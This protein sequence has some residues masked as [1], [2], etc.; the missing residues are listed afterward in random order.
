MQRIIS[1]V[2]F[3]LFFLKS[4]G[5]GV[6]EWH[7]LWALQ[8]QYPNVS[9]E[10]NVQV[11]NVQSLKLGNNV[12][13]QRNSILH[14]GGEDWCDNTG[15][16]EIGDES[17]ISPNCVFY[18]AGSEIYIGKNFDCGPGVMIF[19]S[20]TNYEPPA[21]ESASHDQHVF[22]NVVIGD[23]VICFANVVISPGVEI[24]DGAV[25]GAGAVVLNDVAPYTIVAGVPAKVIATRNRSNER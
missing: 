8:T 7:R 17:C 23:D 14:C 6:R 21:G 3:I 10:R 19:A 11:K 25:I 20:R 22:K 15:G 13:I 1:A 9:F 24:G 18:G 2:S 12:V 4:V 5:G 16:I